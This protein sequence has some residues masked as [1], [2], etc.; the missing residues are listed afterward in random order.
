MSE[1]TNGKDQMYIL[2][3][4]KVNLIEICQAKEEVWSS[5]IGP[6]PSPQPANKKIAAPNDQGSL[7]TVKLAI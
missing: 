7:A 5:S 3:N 2:V 6:A 4:G 1:A